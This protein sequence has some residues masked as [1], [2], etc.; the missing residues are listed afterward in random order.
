MTGVELWRF[1]ESC[2]NIASPVTGKGRVYLPSNGTTVLEIAD[3]S[4]SPEILWDNNQVSGGPASAMLS[5]D[6]F[7]VM[8]RSGV[9][10]C[11]D[12]N[13]GKI[14]WRERVGGTHWGT[15]ILANGHVYAVNHDG[16]A[17]VVAAGD[18]EGKVVSKFALEETIQ[19]SPA[20]AGDALFVRSDKHLWKFAQA[21]D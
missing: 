11:A 18:D 3:G 10:V 6:K 19:S 16:T 5:D 13:T 8:N 9:L 7:L 2:D 12:P 1:D 15:P 21:T 14:K 4:N 17:A 20:I